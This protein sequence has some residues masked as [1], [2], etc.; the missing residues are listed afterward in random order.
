M[1]QHIA[2]LL[3]N[4]C[5]PQALRSLIRGCGKPYQPF[6]DDTV[7][8]RLWSCLY[9][10]NRFIRETAYAT[11]SDLCA[12]FAGPPLGAWGAVF[13]V[14]LQDGLSENWSQVS[15]VCLLQ[16]L[17]HSAAC[18]LLN[19]QIV[20]IAVTRTCQSMTLQAFATVPVCYA[21]LLGGMV[22]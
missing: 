16:V 10:P 18:G 5:L 14:K 11:A 20:I 22:C 19:V 2:L 6:F 7:Q 4:C 8:D 9:H 13:A 3:N 12:L 17:V 1:H 21:K 15:S